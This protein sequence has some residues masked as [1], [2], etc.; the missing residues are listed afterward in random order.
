VAGGGRSA[1][2]HELPAQR[3]RV[4]VLWVDSERADKGSR[5]GLIAGFRGLGVVEG[6]GEEVVSKAASCLCMGNSDWEMR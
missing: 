6:V 1:A 4:L 2:V 3:K 5:S